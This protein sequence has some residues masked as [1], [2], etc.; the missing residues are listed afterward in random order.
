MKGNLEV[1]IV[2]SFTLDLLDSSKLCIGGPAYYSSLAL[3]H[4]DCKNLTV[5]APAD[6]V[7][8]RFA[9]SVNIN[10][11]RVATDVPVFQLT[12]LSNGARKI[13]L[14][15]RVRK[16]RIPKAI[17]DLLDNSL[18][19]VSPVYREVSIDLLKELRSKARFLALDIQGLVRKSNER[20]EVSISWYDDVVK[21]LEL[22][23]FVHA[24][25]SEVVGFTDMAGASLYLSRYCRGI[26]TVS[27]GEKGLVAI[28]NGEPYYVPAL[29]GIR[30]EST[31]TGDIFLAIASYEL[32]LGEDPLTAI[33]KGAIAAGLKVS[34][35]KTPWFSRFEVNVL[36]SKLLRGIKRV[37]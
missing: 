12:Y 5:I 23:D 3:L 6:D 27:N 7:H 24:D 19:I 34:R 14:V 25:L 35:V 2:S 4:Y 28:V 21:A 36:T 29:P 20:G 10:L 22:A 18:V 9:N 32:F 30:G 13:K 33:A 15:K 17:L 1:L 11:I 26:V 8:V 16:I 31:G 37:M